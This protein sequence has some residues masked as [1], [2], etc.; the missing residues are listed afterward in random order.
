[1]AMF[2]LNKFKKAKTKNF[3]SDK[4]RKQYFAIKSYYIKKNE[5]SNS[6]TKK[7]KD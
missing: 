7:K 5:A 4:E 6:V 2:G 3:K 1:M